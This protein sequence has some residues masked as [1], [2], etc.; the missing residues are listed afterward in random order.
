MAKSKNENKKVNSK[1]TTV[2]KKSV[3]SKAKG[4]ATNKK[5]ELIK[6]NS[7]NDITK[8]IKLFV[9]VLVVLGL[10]YL[11]TIAI[12]DNDNGDKKAQESVIQYDEI[13]AGSSF[14]MNSDEYFVVYYDYTDT[15]LAD[16]AMQ[17]YNYTYSGSVKLYSVNM[18]AGFNKPFVAEESSNTSP[19]NVNELSIKGPTLIK[20]VN[21]AVVEY[22]EGSENIIS[23][24][25]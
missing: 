6:S 3:A 11:L 21:G 23:K 9:I 18:N 10:F 8:F 7:S 19:K 17:V 2:N 12:L 15:N 25:K 22:I 16:L 13:L 14:D 5:V 4:N 1:K 24:L 20:F